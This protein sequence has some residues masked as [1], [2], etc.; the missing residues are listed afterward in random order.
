MLQALVYDVPYVV[1]G[2]GGEG[3][4]GRLHQA[5]HQL[6]PVLQVQRAD[7]VPPRLEETVSTRRQICLKRKKKNCFAATSKSGLFSLVLPACSRS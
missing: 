2:V 5:V 1:V 3:E 7:Q 4:H 6:A